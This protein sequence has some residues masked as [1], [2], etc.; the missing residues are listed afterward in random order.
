M[1]SNACFKTDRPIQCPPRPPPSGQGGGDDDDE[2]SRRQ[3]SVQVYGCS[4]RASSQTSKTHCSLCA[5]VT[6]C[7]WP[8]L[9]R[10]VHTGGLLHN[11]CQRLSRGGRSRW[12]L[13]KVNRGRKDP[14]LRSRSE[15]T[16]SQR[17]T[18]TWE[19]GGRSHPR[20]NV[21]FGMYAPWNVGEVTVEWDV[22]S[23]MRAVQMFSGIFCFVG[24]CS[25][26]MVCCFTLKSFSIITLWDSCH[27][28]GR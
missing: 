24:V 4:H 5:C 2:H 27:C 6:L 15:A 8:Q 28:N 1:I 21:M 7:F 25:C 12:E 22:T 26:S 20:W 17:F 3:G 16:W 23:A 19:T 10:R 13:R 18:Q 9:G 14:D 11:V